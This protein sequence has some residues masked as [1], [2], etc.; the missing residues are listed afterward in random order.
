MVSKWSISKLHRVILAQENSKKICYNVEI[1]AGDYEKVK[2]GDKVD[3]VT[4]GQFYK[5]FKRE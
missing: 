1:V 2:E 5:A 3:V 4:V